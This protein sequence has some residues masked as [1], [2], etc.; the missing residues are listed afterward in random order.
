VDEEHRDAVERH[1][2]REAATT[3]RESAPPELAIAEILSP[4]AR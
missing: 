4:G 2:A 1:K 3:R